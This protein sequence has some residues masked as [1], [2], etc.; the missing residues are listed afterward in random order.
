MQMEDD[1]ATKKFHAKTGY[2]SSQNYGTRQR[3]PKTLRLLTDAALKKIRELVAI[4][5]NIVNLLSHEP[6]K[7]F[8][9]NSLEQH[10]TCRI[11]SL[12]I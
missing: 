7:Y 8:L 5:M 10:F 3:L 1:S 4:P 6:Y 12:V 2:L 11:K 9:V